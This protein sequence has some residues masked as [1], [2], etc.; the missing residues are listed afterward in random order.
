M[1]FYVAL[2]YPFAIL[3]GAMTATRNWLF[4][5][6]VLKSR[7]F[8]V[9]TVAVGNLSVGGT[10]KTPFVEF[11]I[12]QL[13]SSHKLATLSRGYGRQTKGY[14][15][16]VP[17]SCAEDIGDE[18]LQIYNKFGQDIK[19]VVCEK[20]AHAIPKMTKK[21]PNLNFILLDDAFQ[22]RYVKA[23]FYIML[24]TYQKPF[25]SDHI[26]PAGTLRE[27]A[28]GAKRADLLVVTKCPESLPD[29]EKAAFTAK[30]RAYLRNET[31]IIFSSLQYGIP[32]PVFKK[33]IPLQTKAFLVSGIA[34]TAALVQEVSRHYELLGHLEFSDHHHY[35]TEDAKKI[36]LL[37]NSQQDVII[38]T[39]E[40]D[41]TKLKAPALAKYLKEIPIFALPVGILLEKEDQ[42]FLLKKLKEVSIAKVKFP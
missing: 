25:F 27:H 11:L 41:A 28:S 19:V 5:K 30:A 29:K 33:S 2:L 6:G 7:Q 22:H 3:Y 36:A 17:T 9:P 21:W 14:Q 34:N 40:K 15:V 10:G 42:Q 8:D 39:T 37:N 13:K 12:T 31:K 20:R 35:N 32:Y 26:L 18:P 23:D 4:D 38:L 16:A 24:T 1:P